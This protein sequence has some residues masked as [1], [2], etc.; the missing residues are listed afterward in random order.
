V[1]NATLGT[2]AG[3]EATALQIPALRSRCT[4]TETLGNLMCCHCF[5]PLYTHCKESNQPQKCYSVTVFD[6]RITCAFEVD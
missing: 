2:P 6:D 1:K 4:S 3:V 5:L